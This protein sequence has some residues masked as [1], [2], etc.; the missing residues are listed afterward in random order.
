[1]NRLT[2]P[3]VFKLQKLLEASEGYRDWEHAIRALSA[4]MDRS[5]TRWN[6]E[7]AA[8][9]CGVSLS[10]LVAAPK[11]KR[12][13]TALIE[14]VRE[15]QRRIDALEKAVQTRS[16]PIVVQEPFSLIS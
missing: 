8:E 1:M 4:A 7:S 14:Q 6:I 15:L 9:A 13:S 11:R 12:P 10:K 2:G 16:E 3:E 5:I